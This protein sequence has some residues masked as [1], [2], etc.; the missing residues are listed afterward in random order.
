[1]LPKHAKGGGRLQE[2]RGGD[3]SSLIVAIEA[4]QGPIQFERDSD[5][6]GRR[7]LCHIEGIDV[8]HDAEK[9]RWFQLRQL[10]GVAFV[11]RARRTA[12]DETNDGQD[13]SSAP[14]SDKIPDDGRIV[15]PEGSLRERRHNEC[16][17]PERRRH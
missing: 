2:F 7:F 14:H 15:T 11:I 1:M 16:E 12:G 6:I 8:A 5:G 10:F 3:A 17:T 9:L 4:G 13:H